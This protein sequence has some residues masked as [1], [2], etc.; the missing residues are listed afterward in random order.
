M[1]VIL[2]KHAGFCFGVKRA[3]DIVLEE[4]KKNN[5]NLYTFGPLIHN[6]Y[7]VN[8][9]AEKGVL[10]MEEDKDPSSYEA[11]T[12]VIRSHGVTEAKL[13]EIKAAGHKIVDATCPFVAKIHN[14]V[15]TQSRDQKHIIVLGDPDHPEVKGIVGWCKTDKISVIS[16]EEEANNFNGNT[17]EEYYLVAQTTFRVK[18]FKEL[19]EI[20]KQKGY[21]IYALN[22]ICNATEERQSEAARIAGEVDVMLVIGGKSSSNSQKLY[23]IC[24]ENCKDTI[25]IQT[26]DDLDLSVPR[27]ISRVGITAGASTPDIIIEEVTKKCQK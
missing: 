2:A 1:E 19:V 23:E 24:R 26:S 22:T 20:L 4:T 13:N 25:F 21:N 16:S 5:S 8:M 10:M 17:N 11:G 9:L 6:E 15:A 18:K 3:L 14:T 7:V 12:V 27:S